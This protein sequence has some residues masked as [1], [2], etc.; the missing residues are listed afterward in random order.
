[1]TV[2]PGEVE[3]AAGVAVD[4]LTAVLEP[5]GVA[6]SRGEWASVAGS[7]QRVIDTASAAQDAAIARLAAIEPEYRE[8]GTEVESH[9][10]LGHEALD[11]PAILSGGA[12]HLGGARSTASAHR[13]PVGR[14]RA[15]RDRYRD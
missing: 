10:A 5:S 8:D 11:A 7:L 14:R 15:G 12:G 13:G 2:G 9:R 1:M 3:A 4:A 6:G